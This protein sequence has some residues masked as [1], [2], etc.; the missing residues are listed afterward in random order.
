MAALCVEW[1]I[2][3]TVLDLCGTV[4]GGEEAEGLCKHSAQTYVLK[5]TEFRKIIEAPLFLGCG[6]SLSSVVS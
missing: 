6:R 2:P 1:I 5:L 3:H 4:A